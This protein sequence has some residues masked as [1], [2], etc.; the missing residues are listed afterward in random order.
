M[1]SSTAPEAKARIIALLQARPG[2]AGVQVTWGSPTE[3]EDI[4]REMIYLGATEIDGE[5]RTLGGQWRHESYSIALTVHV[6]QYGDNEQ[7]T[8]ER[9]FALLDEV[10]GALASDSW[11]GGLL[12]GAPAALERITQ[13]NTP[14]PQQWAAQVSAQVRCEARFTP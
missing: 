10:S 9:A 7:A 2:L 13:T 1:A 12:E 6:A 8:E 3:D 4:R 14:G 11:L 5:W